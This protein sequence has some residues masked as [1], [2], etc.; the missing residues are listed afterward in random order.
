MAIALLCFGLGTAG[1]IAKGKDQV[2]SSCISFKNRDNRLMV[3]ISDLHWGAGYDETSNKDAREDFRWPNAFKAFLERISPTSNNQDNSEPIPPVDLIIVGDL[4]ELWQPPENVDCT[5]PAGGLA[6]TIEEMIN[7]V[8]EI[9]KA[10]NEEV[11]ALKKF[12]LRNKNRVYILP[13][14]HDAALLVPKVWKAWL[15]QFGEAK[16]KFQMCENGAWQ[17]KHVVAEHGHQFLNSD[18]HYEKWPTVIGC[19]DNDKWLRVDCSDPAADGTYMQTTRGEDVVRKVF[20]EQESDFPI[21]DNVYPNSSA[22]E[23]L[24]CHRPLK[25]F[26]PIVLAKLYQWGLAQSWATQML[27]SPHRNSGVSIP[28]CPADGSGGNIPKPFK[29]LDKRKKILDELRKSK[30]EKVKDLYLRALDPDRLLRKLAE[31]DSREAKNLRDRLDKA[32]RKDLTDSELTQLCDQVARI[33][34]YNPCFGKKSKYRRPPV[35]VPHALPTSPGS[36]VTGGISEG[37]R[38]IWSHLSRLHSGI[39]YKKIS[40]GYGVSVFIYGHT[41][42]IADYKV[43]LNAGTVVHVLNSGAFQRLTTVDGLIAL[44]AKDK[45]QPH[46]KL[47]AQP[48]ELDHCYSSVFVR[49]VEKKPVAELMTW[50]MDESGTGKLVKTKDVDCELCSLPGLL[51]KKE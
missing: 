21:L 42:Y 31:G 45:K 43:D 8:V 16:E 48:E 25:S 23:Y 41:H 40:Y 3:F 14:N 49:Y 10:H 9:S 27:Q 5:E 22:V 20:N 26:K 47:S 28:I 12:A 1:S 32:W 50:I 33:E 46:E 24:F 29:E 2:K 4:L 7:T 11:L 34:G 6:C 17:Y 15:N 30:D 18:N 37:V 13:G 19:Y 51:C 39:G 35:S 36:E 44:A 38:R